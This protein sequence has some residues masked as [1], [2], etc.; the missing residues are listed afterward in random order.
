MGRPRF[1]PYPEIS[2]I[3]L[4]KPSKSLI[5]AGLAA[6]WMLH[7]R[8]NQTSRG[9]YYRCALLENN[10]PNGFYDGPSPIL[11]LLNA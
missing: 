4:P 10:I 8:G 3:L 2:H 11:L 9:R 1:D 5:F 6:R 7:A